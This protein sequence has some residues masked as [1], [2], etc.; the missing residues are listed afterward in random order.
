MYT[1]IGITLYCISTW[2]LST[3]SR[4]V[5]RIAIT[6]MASTFSGDFARLR[7]N[8]HVAQSLF[9]KTFVY[10][11]KN[12]EFHLRFMDL[13]DRQPPTALEEPVESSTDYDTHA[14]SDAEDPRAR[15][16]QHSGHFIFS[17]DKEREPEVPHLGWRVGRGT[18]KLK[19]R[20]VDFLLASPGDI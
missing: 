6:K 1:Y 11:E 8:N 18:S 17:F 15:R 5:S 7:P 9:S 14:D 16:S 13:T 10:V 3:I 12:D 19:N 20:N 2:T 4:E